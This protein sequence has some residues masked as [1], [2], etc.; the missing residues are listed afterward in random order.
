M[1]RLLVVQILS[2]A[3]LFA[4]VEGVPSSHAAGAE[5]PPMAVAKAPP[6]VAA[7]PPLVFQQRGV[8]YFPGRIK[9]PLA[10]VGSRGDYDS[11]RVALDDPHSQVS[12]DR[13]A[14][15]I[16]L[17]N[18]FS[19]AK[20]QVA[21]D[22]LFLAEATTQAGK[23]VPGAVHVKVEKKGTSTTVDI[24]SHPSTNDTLISARFE[25]FTVV[26][27]TPAG[28]QILATPA[29]LS[30]AIL[31]PG[32]GVRL[33]SR[34]LS[35]SSH[36]SGAPQD[37]ASVGYLL[38]D[39]SFSVG[40][41]ALRK[42]LVRIQVMSIDGQNA[43]V[44]ARGSFAEMLKTGAWE[45]RT[46]ALSSIDGEEFGRDMFLL[47]I[48]Q[49]PILAPL[50]K[51]G[52]T[53]DDLFTIRL[54]NGRGAVFLGKQAANLPNAQDV[55]RAYFEFNAIGALIAEPLQRTQRDAR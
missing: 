16:T 4:T 47:G 35:I 31:H 5:A 38:F 54:R 50:S 17:V 2:L 3:L 22:F 24:H 36:L 27:K 49:M 33:A 43:P 23:Q 6:P 7:L 29:A 19:Y 30:D 40:I 18:S 15:R 12:V 21:A 34:L 20:K 10:G 55:A 44:I 26:E 46:R 42:N 37:P 53:K 14:R 52:L 28:D 1:K 45:L 11:N 39:A 32:L 51:E 8:Y 41:S 9:C 25:E 48:D 13:A